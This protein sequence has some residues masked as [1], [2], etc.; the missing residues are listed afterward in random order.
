MEWNKLGKITI[1]FKTKLNK[2]AYR[3][4]TCKQQN[5]NISVWFLLQVKFSFGPD[6]NRAVPSQLETKVGFQARS[7]A[8][9][10]CYL[11]NQVSGTMWI[12]RK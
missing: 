4:E 7:S 9:G 10:T 11:S 1:K 6:F 12:D 2:T 5:P 3:E 8:D